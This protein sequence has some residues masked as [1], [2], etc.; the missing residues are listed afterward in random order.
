[1]SIEIDLLAAALK[2]H[3]VLDLKVKKA[4]FARA[5]TTSIDAYC[6]KLT[7]IKGSYQ[8]LDSLMGHVVQ[9]FHPE[10]E[11]LGTLSFNDKELKNYHQKVNFGFIPAAIL[12]SVLAD[13]YEE[14]KDPTNMQ[15]AKAIV[16]WLFVAVADDMQMLSILGKFIANQAH[17]AF[18]YS[19]NGWKQIITEAL[20][21]VDRP[22]FK[23]PID[24]ITNDNVVQQIEDFEL[25]MPALLSGKIKEIHMS[26]KNVERYGLNY[27]NRFGSM[28]AIYKDEDKFKSP[29]GKRKLVGHLDLP[30]NIIWATVD[31]NMLNLI[32]VI[33]NPPKI[34]DVQKAD[35]KIKLFME[36]WKGYDIGINE[37]CCIADFT[38]TVRGLGDAAKM[39]KYFPHEVGIV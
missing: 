5:T 26:E 39:A 8:F 18:G 14:E 30:D 15:I 13:W 11:E 20:A 19:L 27:R 22:A 12:G 35:Y 28:P 16:E 29:L 36:F 24:V 3:T 33:D 31:G 9:G 2:K 10:W 17:G 32:D 37:A 34:T 7:K 6:R 21:N 38:G 4:D 23:I 1:M 25:G